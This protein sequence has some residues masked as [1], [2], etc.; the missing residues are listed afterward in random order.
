MPHFQ[1]NRCRAPLAGLA[2][3]AFATSPMAEPTAVPF[4]AKVTIKESVTFTFAAP[5]F[6]IGS[7]TGSGVATHLGKVTGS[8]QDCFN[9]V[10]AF[11]PNAP[12]YQF[13][14]FGPGLVFVAAS[15]DKVF[16]A[17][18]GTVTYRENAPH[19]VRGNFLITGGTGKFTGATGG[20]TL[21][22]YEDLSAVVS[23]TGAIVFNGQILYGCRGSGNGCRPDSS[24]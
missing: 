9:P 23:A 20:G 19:L 3:V 15:Q 7:L 10:G 8:S 2:L 1:F 12:S 13:S 4:V 17:Y 14:S 21:E 18:S 16:A 24:D 6:G 11:N 5:C 22:G